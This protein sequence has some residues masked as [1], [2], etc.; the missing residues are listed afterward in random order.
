MLDPIPLRPIRWERMRRDEAER[1]VRERASDTDNVII[2]DH[3][4]E[5]LDERSGCVPILAED[6]YEILLKG[7]I[8]SDPIREGD[9]W[10]VVVIR[11]M[12]GVREAGAVTLFA[13]CD[14]TLFVKTVM[15]MDWIR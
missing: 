2:G 9:S 6:V 15:W 10:K 14:G 4:F 7:M 12:P 13:Q 3:A 8:E 1:I 11:R 5:R